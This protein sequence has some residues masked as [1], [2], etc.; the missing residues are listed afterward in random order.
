MVLWRGLPAKQAQE[1]DAPW[2]PWDNTYHTK[3]SPQLL[4]AGIR[5]QTY[6]SGRLRSV[7]VS[8]KEQTANVFS[9]VGLLYLSL[10]Q[11]TVFGGVEAG[12]QDK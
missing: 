1:V 10:L 2:T 3:D 11:N 9:F 12:I 6:H 7:I 4:D 5:R 8:W